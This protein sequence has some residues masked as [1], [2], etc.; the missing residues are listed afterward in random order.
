MLERP[1]IVG[2][3]LNDPVIKIKQT[4]IYYEIVI[5][6]TEQKNYRDTKSL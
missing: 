4:V 6:V 5:I 2:K 1:R 3:I